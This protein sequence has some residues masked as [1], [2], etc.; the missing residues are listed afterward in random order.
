M[1]ICQYWFRTEKATNHYLNHWFLVSVNRPWWVNSGALFLPSLCSTPKHSI[2]STLATEILQF[3]TKATDMHFSSTQCRM[4][5]GLMDWNR[6][7]PYIPYTYISRNNASTQTSTFPLS[8]FRAMI[9]ITDTTWVDNNQQQI[10]L[11]YLCVDWII[12]VDVLQC[13]FILPP[14][15]HEMSHLD[16]NWISLSTHDTTSWVYKR[17]RTHYWPYTSACVSSQQAW[18]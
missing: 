13:H 7:S 5:N 14:P 18:W 9:F 15:D 11:C 4:L 3:C 8:D 10:C 2:F 12:A 6:A 17:S 1:K 16:Y